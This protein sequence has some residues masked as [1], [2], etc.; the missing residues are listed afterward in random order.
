MVISW[1]RSAFSS[2]FYT[3]TSVLPFFVLCVSLKHSVLWKRLMLDHEVAQ[4]SLQQCVLYRD[5]HVAIFV[6]RI[7]LRYI[8]V[9]LDP[10][11]SFD[12]QFSVYRCWCADILWQELTLGTHLST[13]SDAQADDLP[14]WSTIRLRHL[15]IHSDWCL[16]IKWQETILRIQVMFCHFS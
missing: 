5:W 16:A 10:I 11:S 15:V 12:I 13:E 14:F 2:L 9:Y 6:T 4:I 1:N 7:R 8:H 3:K